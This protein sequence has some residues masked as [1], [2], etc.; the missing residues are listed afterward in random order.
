MLATAFASADT[1]PDPQVDFLGGVGSVSFTGSMGMF[2]FLDSAGNLQCSATSGDTTV[3]GTSLGSNSCQLGT[4]TDAFANN[5]GTD[6]RSFTIN[7]GNV[8][9]AGFSAGESSLFQTVIPN[10]AGTGATYSG[11]D[12]GPCVVNSTTSCGFPTCEVECIGAPISSYDIA[13]TS[14]GGFVEFYMTFTNVE[15]LNGSTTATLTSSATSVTAP[16]PGS[17]LLISCGV[18]LLG[19]LRRKIRR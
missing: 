4:A 8:Q 5:T 16:E 11:G 7:F 19:M 12:I 2:F 13:A 14:D 18:G 10:A 15:L 3:A 1:L 6:I 17:M 9:T